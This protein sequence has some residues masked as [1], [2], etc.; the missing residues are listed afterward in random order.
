MVIGNIIRPVSSEEEFSDKHA[1]FRF[2]SDAPVAFGPSVAS[3][4]QG[5]TRAAGWLELR[6]SSFRSRKCFCILVEEAS[7]GLFYYFSTDV[8]TNP[9]G[10]I[11]FEVASYVSLLTNRKAP[12][13]LHTRPSKVSLLSCL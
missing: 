11:K 1:F 5:T 10:F 6:K 4:L 8:A 7:F 3:L 2:S 12:A 9:Q 13:T